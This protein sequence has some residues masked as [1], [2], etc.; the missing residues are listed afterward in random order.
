MSC[1]KKSGSG[2]QDDAC[3]N[4]CGVFTS[5]LLT[6]VSLVPNTELITG[7]PLSL[8]YYNPVIPGPGIYAATGTT[9]PGAGTTFPTNVPLNTFLTAI[10]PPIFTIAPFNNPPLN[11]LQALITAAFQSSP[12][13]RGREVVTVSQTGN[14]SN[15]EIEFRGTTRLCSTGSVVTSGGTLLSEP[16]VGLTALVQGFLQFNDIPK[17]AKGTILSGTVCFRAEVALAYQLAAATAPVPVASL[18]IILAGSDCVSQSFDTCTTVPFSIPVDTSRSALSVMP[19]QPVVGAPGSGFGGALGA[20]LPIGT[21][22]FLQICIVLSGTLSLASCR[23]Q[24][25]KTL[26]TIAKPVTTHEQSTSSREANKAGKKKSKSKSKKRS[27]C[28]S[29]S[30]HSSSRSR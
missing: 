6:S 23:R 1:H 8:P 15:T 24:C 21:R 28:S 16:I 26:N 14:S 29:S 3:S 20:G 13:V 17:Q 5:G 25:S 11:D 4:F 27:T 10:P 7:D 2:D 18:P 9:P 22:L 19:I 30:T 12:G